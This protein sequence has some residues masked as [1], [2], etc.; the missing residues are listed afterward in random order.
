MPAHPWLVY[1]ERRQWRE[2]WRLRPNAEL[3]CKL[4]MQALR[5]RHEAE[6]LKVALT[7]AKR[8]HVAELEDSIAKLE[9]NA[10]R[11]EQRADWYERKLAHHP[12][13]R[14]TP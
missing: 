2:W 4:R 6:A 10:G 5:D 3:I 14:L 13:H 12:A 1:G 8:R 7:Y 11:L 9:W